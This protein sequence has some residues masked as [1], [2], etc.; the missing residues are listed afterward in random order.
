M[1]NAGKNTNG[2]QFFI[3]TTATPWLDGV[4][5]VFGKVSLKKEIEFMV[6]I[7][8]FLGCRWARYCSQNRASQNW[9]ERS[10]LVTSGYYKIRGCANTKT[11]PSIWWSLWVNN[12]FK[13]CVLSRNASWFHCKYFQRRFCCCEISASNLWYSQISPPIHIHRHCRIR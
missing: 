3:T 2:C 12:L 10:T 13:F 9:C 7:F 5:T 1:A 4:H 11:I 8:L 6:L